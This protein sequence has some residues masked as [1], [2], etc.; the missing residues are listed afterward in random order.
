VETVYMYVWITEMPLLY[1]NHTE[2]TH[3]ISTE[4]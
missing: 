4:T 2:N 3:R 1:R